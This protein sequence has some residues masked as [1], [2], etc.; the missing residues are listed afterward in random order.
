MVGE[1]EV[2]CR[3][4]V[5]GAGGI[6]CLL[7]EERNYSEENLSKCT[8]STTAGTWKVPG[9][10]PEKTEINL[11][12]SKCLFSSQMEHCAAIRKKN[13]WIFYTKV[14]MIVRL[15]RNIYT[16]W[17]MC[18]NLM[19][20]QA[21]RILTTRILWLNYWKMWARSSAVGWW[22]HLNFSLT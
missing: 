16:L 12:I 1:C 5:W 3:W 19:F 6:V 15:R 22:C 4:K 14:L 2:V 20:H 13:G 18:G 17:R 9:I 8:L 10:E 11:H 7:V 21:V